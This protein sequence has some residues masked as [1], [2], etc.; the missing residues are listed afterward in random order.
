MAWGE[1]RA[2]KQKTP[3]VDKSQDMGQNCEKTAS[4]PARASKHMTSYR[5]ITFN[6][7]IVIIKIE[8]EPEKQR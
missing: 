7:T 2:S 8:S 5:S 4:G 3:R 6:S 1:E